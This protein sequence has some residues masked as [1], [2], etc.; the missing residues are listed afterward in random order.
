MLSNPISVMSLDKSKKL[1]TKS[2]SKL[3]LNSPYSLI[4]KSNINNN[5]YNVTNKYYN[6]DTN[7]SKKKL[8]CNSLNLYKEI[9][10]I[11]NCNNINIEDNNINYN[12]NKINNNHNSNGLLKLKNLTNRSV[13]TKDDNSTTAYSNSKI[14]DNTLTVFSKTNYLS[15][16]LKICSKNNSNISNNIDVYSYDK[17]II[18]GNN[19]KYSECSNNNNN[20][21]IFNNILNNLSN[22]KTE[23]SPDNSSYFGENSNKEKNKNA[24]DSPIGLNN[25]PTNTDNNNNNN[26]NITKSSYNQNIFDFS[27]DKTNQKNIINNFSN[28]NN[29]N[30]SNTNYS[31]NETLLPKLKL[32]KCQ[33]NSNSLNMYNISIDNNMSNNTNNIFEYNNSLHCRSANPL[34][35]K[36]L[37]DLSNIAFRSTECGAVNNFIN[38]NAT[39]KNSTLFNNINSL[40][41]SNLNSIGLTFN[42]DNNEFNESSSY[43]IYKNDDNKD[44]YKSM[45]KTKRKLSDGTISDKSFTN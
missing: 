3:E 37:I 5:L 11:S 8:S 31:Q 4:K 19:I 32:L 6:K 15:N 40:S 14:T 36:S 45:L 25:S 9:N 43:E 30:N 39:T 1:S 16:S 27:F 26:N 21:K 10:S 18:K 34:S 33:S 38:H 44:V 35:N 42:I 41:R 7:I 12:I 29:H 20:N 22:I 2:L 28:S 13:K 23:I 24:I 17:D